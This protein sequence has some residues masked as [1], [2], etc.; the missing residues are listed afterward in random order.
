MYYFAQINEGR[1]VIKL[2]DNFFPLIQESSQRNNAL[3]AEMM[4]IG[5]FKRA[6]AKEKVLQMAKTN[7]PDNARPIS[8]GWR[9]EH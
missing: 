5:R 3:R 8:P 4:A 1:N 7:P 6:D 9:G 2:V